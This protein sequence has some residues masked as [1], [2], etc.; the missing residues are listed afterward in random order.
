MLSTGMIKI[1]IPLIGSIAWHGG[2]T[3]VESVINSLKTV[4]LIDR[5]KVFLLVDN[6]SENNLKLHINSI[7]LADGLI[8]IGKDFSLLKTFNEKPIIHLTEFKDI[9]NYVD[10]IYPVNTNGLP[11]FVYAGWLPDLQHRYY[12]QFFSES[13]LVERENSIN[14]MLQTTNQIVVS[15]LTA[16]QDVQE[17][18]PEYEGNIEVIHFYSK[19]NTE[20]LRLNPKSTLCKYDLPSKYFICCNQFWRHKNHEVLFRALSL[21]KGNVTLVCTGA[22]ED[23]RDKEWFLYLKNLLNELGLTQ[24][25]PLLGY[26]PRADQVQLIRGAV[27]VIQPSLF[28]GWSTVLEDARGLSKL[29]IVSEIKVHREQ[30][31]ENV[32]YFEPNS[33]LELAYMLDKEWGKEGGISESM[34]TSA[35]IKV[36]SLQ[37]S[38][39]KKLL[40]LAVKNIDL[41]MA[42]LSDPNHFKN[43]KLQRDLISKIF[44]LNEKVEKKE[45]VI[46]HKEDTSVE[47]TK[48]LI[49]KEHALQDKEHALVE[50]TKSLI[51]KETL[52]NRLIEK[53]KFYRLAKKINSLKSHLKT[54]YQ[55]LFEVHLGVLNQYT[56]FPLVNSAIY[57]AP[58][59]EVRSLSKIS[60]VTP[61]FQ[62]ASF[63]ERTIN[64]VISQQYP[65]LEYYIQ[66]GGST[67]GT[68][69]ILEKY[70]HL[71]SGFESIAD[72]G[73]SNAINLAFSRTSGEIMA[74]LNS[75]DLLMPGTLNY[76]AEYFHSHPGIDVIYGNGETALY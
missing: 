8:F 65:L 72:R 23:S 14:F 51:E 6:T 3:Y 44:D 34:E 9:L 66:D 45:I 1:G 61:S 55:R 43:I 74:W 54:K 28:E 62:Q 22:Q 39:G 38:A 56:P 37:K 19:F 35:Q 24:N 50:L 41:M 59:V 30:A 15:S 58:N 12:P 69:E 40:L 63:I 31:L 33:P 57:M 16:K 53:N 60:I 2:I 26:I 36:A 17:F 21:T 32:L 75:D 27:A 10:F 70:S 42:K 13:Q 7:T 46:S 76:V 29:A 52:L 73:Q 5:P 11:G 48:S 64:S 47:L 18:Y 25:V 49:E 71:I 68:L 20:L 67:D 4:D